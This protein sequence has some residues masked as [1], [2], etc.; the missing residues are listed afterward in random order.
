MSV[1]RPAAVIVLAAGEGTRMKSSNTQVLHE[2]CG[3]TP[4][5][6]HA[7]RRPRL[8]PERLS[9]SSATRGSRSQAHLASTGPDAQT[10]VQ[11]SRKAPATPSDRPESVGTIGGTVLVTYGD[12]P[13]LRGETLAAARCAR[14]R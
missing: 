10:V 8:G 11:A 6:P 5:R 2:I 9:S 3:R 4:G 14:T 7:H 1:P 12:T 13:L